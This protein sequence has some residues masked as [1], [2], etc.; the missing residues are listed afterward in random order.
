MSESAHPLLLR[1]IS[2][3]ELQKHRANGEADPLN[4]IHKRVIFDPLKCI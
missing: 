3:I 2:P 1:P 4:A